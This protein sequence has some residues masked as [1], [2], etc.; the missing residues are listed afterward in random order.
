MK[1]KEDLQ[2]HVVQVRQTEQQSEMNL[3]KV[4]EGVKSSAKTSCALAT[5]IGS[6]MISDQ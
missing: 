4:M 6:I 1:L 3:A 2:K 5:A